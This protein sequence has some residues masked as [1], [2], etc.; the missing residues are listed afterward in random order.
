MTGFGNQTGHHVVIAM[1]T[2]RPL[3]PDQQRRHATLV[4]RMLQLARHQDGYVGRESARDAALGISVSY[5][6]A[7]AAIKAWRNDVR[8]MATKDIGRREIYQTCRIRVCRVEHDYERGE[9]VS[10]FD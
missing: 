7:E 9:A 2:L 1:T 5:W 4:D 6:R 3:T 8:H 10:G